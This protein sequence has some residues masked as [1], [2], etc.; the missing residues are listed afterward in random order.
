M[1][2]WEVNAELLAPSQ[3]TGFPE[4]GIKYAICQF[5]SSS[6]AFSV[7]WDACVNVRE[8]P[9]TTLRIHNAFL[10]H[11][12]SAAEVLQKC[13]EAGKEVQ[14][15]KIDHNWH[16]ACAPQAEK[17]AWNCIKKQILRFLLRKLKNAEK[18]WAR[19]R[20]NERERGWTSASGQRSRR[21]SSVYRHVK[22]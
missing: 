13:T 18:K 3:H 12:W 20:M 21:W 4:K 11:L 14:R 7:R 17:W 1:I 22:K 2:P 16:L 10:K 5:L 8:S 9:E 15:E 19:K 6:G